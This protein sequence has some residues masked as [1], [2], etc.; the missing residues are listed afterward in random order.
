MRTTSCRDTA[1]GIGPATATLIRELLAVNALYRLRAAQGV[2]GLAGP[3]GAERLEA[4]C[5]KALAVG[6]PGY[7]TVKGILLAGTE[8]DP[9]TPARPVHAPAHLGGPHALGGQ[10]DPAEPSTPGGEDTGA[11]DSGEVA[12]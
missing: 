7:R 5:A 2:L 1:A 12:S 9:A 3:H 8:T 4:A 11:D 10:P 6:D